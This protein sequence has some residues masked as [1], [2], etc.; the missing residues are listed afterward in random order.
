MTVFS[1]PLQRVGA[2]A[3]TLEPSS[4]KTEPQNRVLR[5][6]VFELHVASG[7]LRKEG[8]L[9]HLRH[10]P[11]SVLQLLLE[12]A[13]GLISRQE[14][15]DA[16]WPGD[17]DIDVEQG[18]NHCM[19]EIRA[20]LGDR[21]ESPRFIQTLPRRGY[22]FL[23][24]VHETRET[25]VAWRRAAPP[26]CAATLTTGPQEALVRAQITVQGSANTL[27]F[28]RS[29]ERPASQVLELERDLVE[30]LRAAR[31][32]AQTGPTA[33]DDTEATIRSRF[34]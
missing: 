8:R 11:A 12:N 1:F 18:L 30:G 17:I 2:T 20:A 33:E 21:P 7:E 14:I 29:W 15:T 4:S 25:P 31:E 28:S 6:G 9:V 3:T 23:V 16:V 13:G 27:L 32:A 24:D 5:F 19:K 26:P 10:Q 34:E 22:R